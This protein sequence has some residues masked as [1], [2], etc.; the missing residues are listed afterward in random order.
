MPVRR[1][2]LA[3][4]AG[5]LVV[6]ASSAFGQQTPAQPKHTGLGI[7]LAE[8]PASRRNDPRAQVYVIDHV[9]G[10][11]K[12]SRKLE[13]QNDTEAPANPK[14][15]VA[16]ASI[17]DGE[18]NPGAEGDD[19]EIPRWSSLSV[20]TLSLGPGQAST[21]EL[22]IDV[23]KDAKD[24]EY[25]G[26]VF[27]EVAAERGQ[28]NQVNRVGVRIYLSV[29]SGTEPRSDFSVSTLA[30]ERA[31]NGT[32]SVVASV[33]NT[34]GRALDMTGELRLAHGPAGLSAGPFPAELG[35]TLGIGDTEP[36]RVELDKDLPNGP[37]DA[38]LV[39]RSGTIERTVTATIT[40]PDAGEKALVYDAHAEHKSL[41]AL[42]AAIVLVTV[43]LILGSVVFRGRLRLRRR[44]RDG[45]SA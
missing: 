23:P 34:G 43:L 41:A 31:K 17:K 11:T 42:I 18:F 10:G 25:Y 24:G 8:A 38:T 13:V 39:M 9:A 40:F 26:A 27:A 4:L 2:I 15:Y 44:Q 12:F 32:P 29:G 37:W 30:A 6:P 22:T 14:V 16:P 36:V 19:G 35:T 45:T 1:I 5:I 7:R 28:I 20:S 33:T 21:L 3:V